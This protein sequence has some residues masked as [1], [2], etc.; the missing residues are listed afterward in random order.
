[1]EAPLF[2][3]AEAKHAF[4]RA[5]GLPR[6]HTCPRVSVV[7]HKLVAMSRERLAHAAN[8]LRCEISNRQ[9]R[10]I[11]FFLKEQRRVEFAHLNISLQVV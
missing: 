1:M 9:L 2:I 4:R 5:L 8:S 10:F 11:P 7:A 6:C 3:Q